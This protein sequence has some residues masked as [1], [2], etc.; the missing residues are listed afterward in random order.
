M[1]QH[2]TID[3]VE[4]PSEAVCSAVAATKGCS[5]MDIRPLGAIIDPDALDTLLTGG[6]KTTEV[7]FRYCGYNVTVTARH[8]AVAEPSAE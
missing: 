5:P 4:S 1:V 2:Y 7:S 6:P 3:A 8:V